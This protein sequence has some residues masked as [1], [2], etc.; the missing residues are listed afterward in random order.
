MSVTDNGL[1]FVFPGQ[2]SQSV[3]MLQ[4]LAAEHAEVQETYAE[5]SD[6]LGF[7]LWRLVVDGPAE[8]LNLTENTQPAMLAAGVAVWRVWRKVSEVVPAWSA[9]HSLGEYT[10]LVCADAIAYRDAVS[11]V[12]ERARLMQAAVAPGVGAMAAILG[13]DDHVV[14]EVCS[15]VSTAEQVVTPANFNAPGQVVIAGHAAA[16]EKA[17]EAAKSHG[18]K[19]AVILPVSVP[20]HCPLMQEAAEKFHAILA[21]VK[22]E[23]PAITVI[24]NVD[25]APHPAPEVIAS[26]LEK[27]LYGSVRWADSVRFMYEQGVHRFVECGP[28]KVLAGL[29]KRIAPEARAEAVFSP[30]SL[31]KALELVK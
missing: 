26:A 5:A 1:A 28:G 21:G 18:A 30:D 16:V 3:G 4:E 25:V 29:T 17:I 10:A 15:S 20:S 24:H 13:L 22:I 9:G 8:E 19:R 2:G 23:S 6:V 14:V 12:R 7:D 27:Q 11:L 31:N